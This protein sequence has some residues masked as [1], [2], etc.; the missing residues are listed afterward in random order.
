MSEPRLNDEDRK[1]I[2]AIYMRAHKRNAEDELLRKRFEHDQMI[3]E[4][5]RIRAERK[6][7]EGWKTVTG[8]KVWNPEAKAN[9]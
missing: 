1:A 3:A 2:D 8:I 4:T 7:A 9:D 6:E 5:D